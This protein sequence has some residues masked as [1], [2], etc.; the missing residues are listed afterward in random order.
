[1]SKQNLNKMKKE[2]SKRLEEVKGKAIELNEYLADN[3]ELS[4]QEYNSCEAICKLL[5]GEG[6]PV[7]RKFAGQP[8][9][10]K[11]I[12]KTA[13]NSSI[14]IGILAEYDALPEV[15]HACGHCASGSIS[16]LA[17]IALARCES[18][19]GCNIDIIGTPD[20]EV[21]GG[22]VFMA[23]KGV[24]D[25]Y[26]FVIMIHMGSGKMNLV[27]ADMIAL[28]PLIFR[29]KGRPAHAAA[30]PWDG[31]N[32]L[33][34]A[35]LMLHA[36][37]MLRQHVRPETRIHGIIRYGGDAPNIVPENAII[38]LLVRS[39]DKYYLLKV[40]EMV[41]DCAQG[42]AICTQ[43]EVE[44]VQE[45]PA[46]DNMLH[47]ETGVELLREI[48]KELGIKDYSEEESLLSGSSDMGN[49]SFRCPAFQTM[50]SVCEEDITIHS[51]EFAAKMKGEEIEKVIATGAEVI[52][53]M[54][55]RSVNEPDLLEK[56]RAEFESTSKG[57]KTAC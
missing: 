8:T 45:E 4:G 43:T 20:E 35:T 38:D 55:L 12:V 23:D 57:G 3:P 44:I 41:R 40:A 7:E 50:L 47:I 13:A 46:F 15:G 48:Y 54:V 19:Q 22:K 10:F 37:D 32:A 51:R 49:V 36:V 24:F 6:I 5:E 56:M 53:I 42:A 18:L 11:G 21:R 28:L 34:G 1:M 29:F 30:C 33:N 14:K 16:V 25:D 9:A 39:P 52:G 17:A 31:K 27:K 2:F 26:S